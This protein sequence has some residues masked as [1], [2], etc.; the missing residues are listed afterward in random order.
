MAKSKNGMPNLAEIMAMPDT[1]V[2]YRSAK[3]YWAKWIAISA[4]VLFLMLTVGQSW[5]DRQVTACRQG[6]GIGVLCS[7]NTWSDNHG[8]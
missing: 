1:E 7:V 6:H 4:V 5:Y 2:V 3:W 8:L